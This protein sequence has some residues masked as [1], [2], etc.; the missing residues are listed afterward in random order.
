MKTCASLNVIG[1]HDLI[2]KGT[3]RRFGGV[4]VALEEAC[5]CEGRL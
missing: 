4:D 1:P 5:H 3:T 2:G